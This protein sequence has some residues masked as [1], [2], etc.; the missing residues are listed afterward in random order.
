MD[1]LELM[2]RID[3]GDATALK[4]LVDLHQVKVLNLCIRLLG[5]RQ[6][7]EDV[8][9]EVFFQVY[10][11]AG[12]FR[13]ECL[14]STWIYRIAVNRCR[15]FSRDNKKYQGVN[16]LPRVLQDELRD[17]ESPRH[18]PGPESARLAEELKNL[19]R[20]AVA[21]LPEKQKTMLI[22]HHYEGH[23]YKEIADILDVSLSS[24]ESGLHRAKINL[25]KTL[26]PRVCE[27]LRDRKL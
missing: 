25:Q 17:A 24:V 23:S 16:A 18:A 10:R 20:Q 2:R 4:T 11:S 22:L 14:V 13:G 19:I 21:A 5:T 12:A 9:Q 26:S 1:D 27:I 8:A 3:A 7:A 6:N 15:N